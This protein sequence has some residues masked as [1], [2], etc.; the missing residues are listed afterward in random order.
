[1]KQTARL[2]TIEKRLRVRLDAMKEARK[3]RPAR[4]LPCVYLT[5]EGLDWPGLAE[6]NAQARQMAELVGVELKE[7]WGI[8][9][10][11]DY[12]QEET[13]NEQNNEPGL[14][15]CETEQLAARTE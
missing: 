2:A 4:R 8:D 15:T 3:P 6:Q 10:S 13:S 5:S 14:D 9:P 7:W 1:M 11:N 12:D